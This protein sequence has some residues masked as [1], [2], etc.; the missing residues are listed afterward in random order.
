MRFRSGNGSV[1]CLGGISTAT[2]LFAL[3][4]Q[5]P[6]FLSSCASDDSLSGGLL[7]FWGVPIPYNEDRGGIPLELA[8]VCLQVAE[9]KADNIASICAAIDTIMTEHPATRL[10]VFGEAML[11]HYY[12]ESDPQAYQR[13]LAEEL[14]ASF[15]AQPLP[16]SSAALIAAHCAAAR[17]VPPYIAYGLSELSGG[18]LYN[19]QIVIAP[20]GMIVARHRKQFLFEPMDF[21]N[22]FT[23]GRLSEENNPVVMIDG[24]RLGLMICHDGNS[25]WLRQ[26]F[27]EK[28]VDVILGSFASFDPPYPFMRTGSWMVYSN[29]IGTEG[30]ASYSGQCFIADPLGN[31]VSVAA[32][33]SGS[34]AWYTIHAER[35]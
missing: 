16:G 29:R 21:P 8:S 32:P 15:P 23:A 30:S 4:V 18:T 14:P 1:P 6:V 33:S 9:S 31:K 24:V 25:V 22:G 34:Y 35:K 19:S 13:S 11:G 12:N 20:D 3:A 28:E 27:S 10:V 7:G 26:H 5:I 2:L 17:Y